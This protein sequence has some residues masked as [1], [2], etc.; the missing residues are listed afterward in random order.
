MVGIGLKSFGFLLHAFLDFQDGRRLRLIL[1]TMNKPEWLK[2]FVIG[3][4]FTS[5]SWYKFLPA[6]SLKC[7]LFLK[8]AKSFEIIKKKTRQQARENQRNQLPFGQ[9]SQTIPFFLK[10]LFVYWTKMRKKTGLSTWC[11]GALITG[12][13]SHSVTNRIYGFLLKMVSLFFRLLSCDRVCALLQSAW[14][15]VGGR[16]GDVIL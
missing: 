5:F 11:D 13:F 6:K 16:Q 3:P 7:F 12:T 1:Q 4:L 10:I 2:Q 14:L 15:C 9:M 8:K